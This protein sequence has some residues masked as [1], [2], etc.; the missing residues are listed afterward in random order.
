MIAINNDNTRWA[1]WRFLVQRVSISVGGEALAHRTRPSGGGGR[2][3]VGLQVM[4]EEE[5]DDDD[6][7]EEEEEQR[8]DPEAGPTAAARPMVPETM[9]PA[10]SGL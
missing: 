8:Q 3:K 1:L 9:I 6:E 2:E 4:D 5:E 10:Y 7:G